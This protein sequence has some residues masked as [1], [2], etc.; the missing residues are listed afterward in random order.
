M[1]KRTFGLVVVVVLGLVAAV[2]AQPAGSGA[3]PPAAPGSAADA[4]PAPPPATPNPAGASDPRRAACVEAM[5]ADPGFEKLVLETADARAAKERDKATLAAHE[6]SQRHVQKN[7]RHVLWAYAAMW[8]IA[9]G[10]V[11]YLWRR[12]QGLKTEIAQLRRDLDAAAK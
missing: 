8:I 7:E 2:A 6:E 12:Q 1:S 3:P 5:N 11:I 10:F 4:P 9:A